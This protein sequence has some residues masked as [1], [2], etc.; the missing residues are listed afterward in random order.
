MWVHQRPRARVPGPQQRLH[1]EHML[2]YWC[3]RRVRRPGH[4]GDPGCDVS[5]TSP[6]S[7]LSTPRTA[8]AAVE[9]GTAAVGV[10]KRRYQN[11]VSPPPKKVAVCCHDILLNICSNTCIPATTLRKGWEIRAEDLTMIDKARASLSFLMSDWVRG[12]WRCVSRNVAGHDG[13]CEG[14]LLMKSLLW[15]AKEIII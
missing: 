4:V 11:C 1:A 15:V 6:S 7:C 3:R 5:H 8:R 14:S 9:H 10:S 12:I 2:W 13:G